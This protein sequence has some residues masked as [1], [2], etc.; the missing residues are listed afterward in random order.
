MFARGLGVDPASSRQEW[1]HGRAGAPLHNRRM[2]SCDSDAGVRFRY[3]RRD[4]ICKRLPL[5][6]LS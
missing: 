2:T 1:R 3:N 6:S 5:E 4:A